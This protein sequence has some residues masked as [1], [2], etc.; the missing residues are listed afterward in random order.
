MERKCKSSPRLRSSR[1]CRSI[2]TRQQWLVFHRIVNRFSIIRVR[3]L[4]LCETSMARYTV[5]CQLLL[6]M[7]IIRLSWMHF[8]SPVKF[9]EC[10]EALDF[11]KCSTVASSSQWMNLQAGRGHEFFP[12]LSWFT[13]ISHHLTLAFSPEPGRIT[14]KCLSN[15]GNDLSSGLSIC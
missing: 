14:S 2:L 5:V 4:E 8:K 13:P 11:L 6:K 3:G 7:N 9:I 12:P 10:R 1:K 15:T